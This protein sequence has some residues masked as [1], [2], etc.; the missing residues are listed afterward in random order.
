MPAQLN[1]SNIGFWKCKNSIIQKV[2]D[3]V[4]GVGVSEKLCLTVEQRHSLTTFAGA[5]SKGITMVSNV[6]ESTFGSYTSFSIFWE[7]ELQYNQSLNLSIYDNLQVKDVQASAMFLATELAR[8]TTL[9]LAFMD[10]IWPRVEIGKSLHRTILRLVVRWN[11]AAAIIILLS[12]LQI[13]LVILAY[14]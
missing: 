5:Q 11:E 10:T 7:S 13:L 2:G 8:R 4:C 9:A 6:N 1:A 3:S 14:F 12:L